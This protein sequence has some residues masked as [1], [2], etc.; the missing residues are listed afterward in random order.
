MQKKG[1]HKPHKLHAPL[2]L[3]KK[4][5]GA[6]VIEG[7]PGLGLVGTIATGF[8]LDHLKCEKIGSYYFEDPPAT[9]AVHGCTIVDPIGIYYNKE[10]NLVIVHAITSAAG[11][12]FAAA[13]LILNLC[14]QI[15]ASQLI[16]LEGVG[17]SEIEETRGFFYTSHPQMKRTMENLGI[18][19]LGEGIIMGVTAALLMRNQLPILSLFAETHSKLPDSKAAA[20]I[21]EILDRL[22][23]LKVNYEPLLRQAEEFEKKLKGML[24]QTLKAREMK[25]QKQVGYIG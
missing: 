7:F 13:D 3:S 6:T 19:C 22:L 15:K 14:E 8:L 2:V 16:T 4:P 21:I 5:K 9:L 18:D 25:D 12:E 1:V 11:I 20:K 10:Y 23:G 17:S 24:E